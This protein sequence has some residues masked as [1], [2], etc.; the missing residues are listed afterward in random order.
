VPGPDGWCE[1]KSTGGG[2]AVLLPG[3]FDDF[4]QTGVSTNG[5]KTIT[6]A[7]GMV[8]PRGVRYF[9]LA[10]SSTDGKE[11]SRSTLPEMAAKAAK[12]GTLKGQRE[13]VWNGVRGIELYIQEVKTTLKGRGYDA[14]GVRYSLT[15]EFPSNAAPEVLAEVDKFLDSLKL[16]K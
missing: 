7:V 6:Y 16:Q 13:V 12:E 5:T 1:A 10:M 2:F 15:A 4:S 8:T 9:A 11:L 14:Q 3:R